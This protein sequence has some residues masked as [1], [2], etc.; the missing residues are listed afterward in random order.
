MD[1]PEQPS[2]R[3]GLVGTMFTIIE[4]IILF[5]LLI[6]FHELGHFIV[7]RIFNIE[8]EEFGFGFPPRMLTLGKFQGTIISL[9]WIP[10][11]GFVRPKAESDANVAGGLASASPWV[12]MAVALGGPVTNLVIGILLF[13]L[14][15]SQAGMPDRSQVQIFSINENSPA[16]QA[17]LEPGDVF[18]RIND[19][20]IDSSEKLSAIVQQN[21]GNE[22][23]MVIDR[24]GRQIEMQ[25]TP[26]LDPPPGEGALGISMGNPTIEIGLIEAVPMGVQATYEQ[27]RMLISLPG[28]LIAGQVQPEQARFVGPKGIYDMYAQAREIDEEISAAAPQE[29]IPTPP[30]VAT[31]ALMA[32]LSVALGL[33]NLLPIPALDGGRI[34]F[35]LPEIL[36]GKRIPQEYENL[37]HLVGFAALIILMIYVT[38]Q[39]IINPIQMP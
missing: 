36:T 22:I 24:D 33:T 9:N 4:F 39:D 37:V 14:V 1:F 7:C 11:G 2:E 16:Q 20:T 29:D 6:F 32:M 19:E 27:A 15:F 3:I 8:V 35:T 5:G 31:L 12:R 17:G 13:A 21:R 18:V 23:T 30:A 26:R 34:L 28:Q 25:A 10:F 38:T